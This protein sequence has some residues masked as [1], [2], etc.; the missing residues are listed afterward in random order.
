MAKKKP[1]SEKLITVNAC[2]SPAE[3]AALK[4]FAADRDWPPSKAVR[5]LAAEGLRNLGYLEPEEP[6]TGG[7]VA[8]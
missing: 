8:A 7:Q 5:R 1:V 6:A 4:K 3:V 2:I